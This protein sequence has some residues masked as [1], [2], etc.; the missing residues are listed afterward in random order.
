MP[1]ANPNTAPDLHSQSGN[2][3]P[4]ASGLAT[5]HGTLPAGGSDSRQVL[6]CAASHF[7]SAHSAGKRFAI[8]RNGNGLHRQGH[9]REDLEAAAELGGVGWVARCPIDAPKLVHAGHDTAGGVQVAEV[10]QP[11]IFGAH[12]DALR[13]GGTLGAHGVEVVAPL[14]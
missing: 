1:S 12:V 6:S 4:S 14:D 10:V 9:P 5:E 3:S 7:A 2:P 8:G 13:V 11:V